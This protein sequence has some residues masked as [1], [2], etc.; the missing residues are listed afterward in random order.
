MLKCG[1]NI[2]FY[3]R[4]RR[5]NTYLVKI[6]KNP[7]K[8]KFTRGNFFS[9]YNADKNS[10]GLGLNSDLLYSALFYSNAVKACTLPELRNTRDAIKTSSSYDQF[11]HTR[12]I[13]H[14]TK[15]LLTQVSV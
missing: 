7:Y 5:S 2:I 8:T 15:S 13:K 12:L 10:V 11:T 4:T 9:Q 14:S 6:P 3:C 1:T